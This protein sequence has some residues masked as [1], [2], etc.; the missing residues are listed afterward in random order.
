MAISLHIVT[1]K[2]RFKGKTVSWLCSDKAIDLLSSCACSNKETNKQTKK[3]S[4]AK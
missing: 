3:T 4:A 2:I 1:V